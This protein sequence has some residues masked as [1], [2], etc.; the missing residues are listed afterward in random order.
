MTKKLLVDLS[1][2][3]NS[4][5]SNTLRVVYILSGHKDVKKNSI[6]CIREDIS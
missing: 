5:K 3:L 4:E 1:P 6:K 2:W